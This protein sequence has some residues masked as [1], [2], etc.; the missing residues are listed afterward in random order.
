MKR[1]EAIS[2]TAYE[3]SLLKDVPGL[4]QMITAT[5][6]WEDYYSALQEFLNKNEGDP[7][8]KPFYDL[9]A[10]CLQYPRAS[11]CIEAKRFSLSSNQFKAAAGVKAMEM[12]I[13]GADPAETITTMNDSWKRYCIERR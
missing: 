13:A 9:S 8:N 10:L 6:A 4:E 5:N 11:A 2:F 1:K 3:C 7:P 12:L